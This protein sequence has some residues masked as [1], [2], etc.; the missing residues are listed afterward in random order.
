MG[1]CVW[2][3]HRAGRPPEPEFQRLSFGRG[4]I[5]A[6]RFA[7][8]GQSV[9]YGAA[10]DGKPTQLFWAKAG[11]FESRPL[12]IEAEILAISPSGPLAVLLNQRFGTVATQGTLALF[13]LTGSAPRKLL[14]DVQEA[15]WSPDGSN[16]AVIHYVGNGRCDLEYPLGN[17]LYETTAGA[18]W[19]GLS[20]YSRGYDRASS[21]PG[22]QIGCCG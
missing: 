16:L 17:K 7:P 20:N 22:R 4:M 5:R 6:A 10:W 9:V 21:F 2:I 14:D 8:D 12:G 11:S 18:R 3:H 1:G 15:D 19:Q 13:S